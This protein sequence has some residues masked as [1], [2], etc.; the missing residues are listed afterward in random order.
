ML[1]TVNLYHVHGHI[2]FDSKWRD[3][4]KNAPDALVLG[5]HEYF[6]TFDNPTSVFT[7]TILHLLRE[8]S[9][10]FIGLSMH[11]DNLRR[12]LYYSRREI[13]KGYIAEGVK[14][15]SRKVN[16][17]FALLKTPKNLA[18]A[19]ALE[20]SLLYLGVKV[21]W[22]RDYDKIPSRLRKLYK[23]GGDNWESVW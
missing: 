9:F 15:K 5:E 22:L 18:V 2:R 23:N 19:T 17:H 20:Q 8:H 7:Y 21:V 11:D 10:L 3:R 16:R 12:L 4:T 14:P 6:E 13:M 1:D